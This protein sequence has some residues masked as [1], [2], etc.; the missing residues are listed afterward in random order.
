MSSRVRP[1][2]AIACSAASTASTTGSTMSRRPMREIPMPVTATL[3]SNLSPAFGIG[4]ASWMAGRSAGNGPLSVSPVGSN[5]GTHTSSS[6]S[7]THLHLH[8]DEHLVGGHV[9][10]VGGEADA[11]VLLD[12][13]DRDHVRRREARDPHL[14]VEG[15][16]GDDAR[17]PTPRRPPIRASGSR[18]RPRVG[19]W[20]SS[21]HA[22]AALEAQL[23]VLARLPEELVELASARAAPVR[24]LRSR[25]LLGGFDDHAWQPTLLVPDRRR[26]P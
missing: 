21:P 4:R 11:V 7:N 23:P 16:T 10:E 5:S 13:D 19:G 6:C 20:R 15:E 14:L 26:V 18:G 9:H 25:S 8:A 12:G 17:D 1:A 3:S 2:S 24:L 22:G